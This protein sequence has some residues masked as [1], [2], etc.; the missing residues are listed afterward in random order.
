MW[1]SVVSEIQGKDKVKSLRL[2]NVVTG[3][4]CTLPI[5][6]IFIFIGHSPNTQLF[7]DQL[8]MDEN[9][10]LVTDNMM[11]TNVP[12]VFAA[13]EAADPHYRQVVTSA[14]MGAAAAIQAGHF[15]DE[16]VGFQN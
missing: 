7:K 10:Y 6:G 1:N 8:E 11:R 12:G 15:L 4:E 2:K 14:G 9:N 3:E 5:D 16:S 13:G